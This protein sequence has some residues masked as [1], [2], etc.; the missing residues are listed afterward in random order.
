MANLEQ[1]AACPLAHALPAFLSRL[2]TE[3]AAIGGTF[4]VAVH[5]GRTAIDT[6]AQAV[7]LRQHFR[8]ILR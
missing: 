5:L 4:P 6:P 2:F 7:L 8:P 3:V 1:V